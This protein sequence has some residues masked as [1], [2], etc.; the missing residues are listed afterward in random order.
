MNCERGRINPVR[1]HK[2]L[3]LQVGCGWPHQLRPTSGEVSVA[4]VALP[5]LLLKV[6]CLLCGSPLLGPHQDGLRKFHPWSHSLPP[7]WVTPF[8]SEEKD[9]LELKRPT[10]L[11]NSRGGAA[12]PLLP[13]HCFA[14][15]CPLREPELLG[16]GQICPENEICGS[17]PF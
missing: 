3:D 6:L 12:H 2:I 1:S 4:R 8:L 11:L 7:A 5:E 14:N 10:Y 17:L 13:P 9:R 16:A 15:G